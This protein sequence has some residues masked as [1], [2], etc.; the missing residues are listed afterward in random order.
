[1][2]KF[3]IRLCLILAGSLIMASCEIDVEKAPKYSSYT[4]GTVNAGEL[5]TKDFTVHSILETVNLG[6]DKFN[7]LTFDCD[8]PQIIS[9]NNANNEPVLLFRD[10]TPKKGTV[11]IDARS[12]AIALITFRP[13]LGVIAGDDYAEFVSMITS[14]SHFERLLEAV[15]H[16]IASNSCIYD[17]T[18][19]ELTA[20][21]GAVLKDLIGDTTRLFGANL[22]KV[23]LTERLGCWPIDV[24]T[25]GQSLNF[26]VPGGCPSY[27]F[28]VVDEE[29]KESGPFTI[30][31]RDN[32]GVWDAVKC[33]SGQ[34]DWLYGNNTTYTF[35]KIN[36]H[37]HFYITRKG[38]G[39]D[40]FV[41]IA[42]CMLQLI[43]AKI[44]DDV[45]NVI[46]ECV[47]HELEVLSAGGQLLNG[48]IADAAW[49][50]CPII[51]DILLDEIA[52]WG[53]EMSVKVAKQMMSWNRYINLG[54]GAINLLIRV[55]W[56]LVAD[57]EFDFC[58]QCYGNDQFGTCRDY[59][60]IVKGNNQKGEPGKELKDSLT[61]Q[62]VT[63]DLE[64]LAGKNYYVSFETESGCGRVSPRIVYPDG[65]GF[66][67]T[68]WE[69]GDNEGEQKVYAILSD[70]VYDNIYDT[71]VFKARTLKE[72]LR[73]NFRCDWASTYICSALLTPNE[74][75][76][77]GRD[78]L[79]GYDYDGEELKCVVSGY[80]SDNFI[81]IEVESY[82]AKSGHHY[83]TDIYQG[84]LTG[85]NTTIIGTLTYDDGAGCRPKAVDIDRF[86]AKSAL[87]D[88]PLTN[89][90]SCTDGCT[91]IRK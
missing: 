43:G 10:L 84:T 76:S 61:V 56:L 16:S 90:M 74:G 25:K 88:V 31:T 68:K 27:R 42:R 59:L 75:G 32:W 77:F 39:F 70:Y 38:R 29:G 50:I 28:T 48:Q 66:V 80:I 6:D 2:K 19:T 7:V 63:D 85:D 15:E 44:D 86:L 46:V 79:R 37:R 87:Q 4:R 5:D 65:K 1:M 57:D 62:I 89:S 53:S 55:T 69:L 71:V 78:I 35:P 51:Y 82:E 3:L 41:Q 47:A 18:N 73:L 8:L 20:A 58:T 52:E 67:S 91:S 36:S 83:R 13:D 22:Q 24:Q 45:A 54:E 33:L 12:T 49:A 81:Y 14:S 40:T 23:R 72:K 26:R 64:E 60:R 34:G 17:T 30:Y 21:A 11:E 9:V